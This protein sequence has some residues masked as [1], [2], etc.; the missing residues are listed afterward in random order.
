MDPTT[1][2]G[3]SL[4][5]FARRVGLGLTRCR[6]EIKLGNLRVLKSGRR[7][8]VLSTEV[9]KFFSRLASLRDDAAGLEAVSRPKQ[10]SGNREVTRD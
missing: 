10:V 7:T 1:L 2:Q 3:L 5:E 9:E 4:K 8:I 6:I